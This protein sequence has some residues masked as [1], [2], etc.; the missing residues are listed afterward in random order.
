MSR[1][2]ITIDGPHHSRR[3]LRC[4]RLRVAA[5]AVLAALLLAAPHI[6]GLL[7]QSLEG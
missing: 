6:A 5:L 3:A 4:A 7:A 2:P 1:P